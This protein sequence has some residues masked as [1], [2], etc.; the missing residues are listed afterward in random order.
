MLRRKAGASR[1]EK[2]SGASARQAMAEILP[3]TQERADGKVIPK[4]ST[5]IES[6]PFTIQNV[7]Q[8]R[9]VSWP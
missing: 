5:S 7:Y 9:T 1:R 3:K 8:D 6:V 2:F 4:R